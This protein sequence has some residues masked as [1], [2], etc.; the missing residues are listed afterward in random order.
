MYRKEGNSELKIALAEN[1]L[2]AW[3]CRD[4][5]LIRLENRSKLVCEVFSCWATQTLS[6]VCLEAL[7]RANLRADCDDSVYRMSNRSAGCGAI[8]ARHCVAPD[9]AFQP[10][11][12]LRVT[13]C[14]GNTRNFSQ[15]PNELLQF[16]Q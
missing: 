9:H 7:Y 10:Q 11:A 15:V 13:P 3:A 1:L 5:V 2:L 6:S 14:I 12:D 4:G 8:Q 16:R